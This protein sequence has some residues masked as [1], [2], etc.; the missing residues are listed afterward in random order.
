MSRGLGGVAG[1]AEPR[2]NVDGEETPR[3][4]STASIRADGS[5][6]I[7]LRSSRKDARTSR[8]RSPKGSRLRRAA[9]SA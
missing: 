7:S 2:E 9:S 3:S 8:T 4:S 1:E 6:P 5:E